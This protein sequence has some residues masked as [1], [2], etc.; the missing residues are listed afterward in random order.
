MISELLYQNSKVTDILN[1]VWTGGVGSEVA[2]KSVW[3]WSS[4]TDKPMLFRNFWKGWS[5]GDRSTTE[6]KDAKYKH[7]FALGIK[8]SRQ[9]SLGKQ[10]Q[11]GFNFHFFKC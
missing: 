9:F 4:D 7:S 8:M 6:I 1:E 11:E 10:G 5:G 3:F 2:R